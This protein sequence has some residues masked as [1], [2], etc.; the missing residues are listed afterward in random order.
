MHQFHRMAAL[1]SLAIWQLPLMAAA[2]AD[3]TAAAR[4]VAEATGGQ[5]KALKGKQFDQNCNSTVEYE[6]EVIDLNGDGQPEVFT[7][8][9]SSCFGMAGVHMDLYVK[10][11]SGKWKSQ[12]GFPGEPMVLKSKNL[13]YPDIEI[14][15]PGNCFPVWRWNGANYD[16]HKKCA[17]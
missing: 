2:P 17:R 7:K 16:I 9:Y 1:V 8:R 11:K 3:S 10:G 13:G 5:F 4:V 6:A 12:F 14:G 15:G